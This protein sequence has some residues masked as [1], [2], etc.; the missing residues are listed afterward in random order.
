MM[1]VAVAAMAANAATF[2]WEY[3]TDSSEAGYMVYVM[4]GDTVQTSWASVSDIA[5]ASIGSGEVKNIYGDYIATGSGISA[6]LAKGT[7]ASVYYV[8]VTGDKFSSS[9]VFT[10]D[11]GLIYGELDSS[12]GAFD[13]IDNEATFSAFQ[14]VGG[15]DT[16]VDSP[17]PTSGVLMLVGAGVLALRRKQK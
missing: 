11:G 10:L 3:W 14:S 4:L 5:T 16:P 17:E 13:E 8:L 2:D 1:L 6:S 9:E 15:G 12:P 7:D